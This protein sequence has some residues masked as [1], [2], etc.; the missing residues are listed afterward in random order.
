MDK[1]V[2]EGGVRLEGTV[3]VSGAKNSALPIM[4]ASMLADGTCEILGVPRVRDVDTLLKLL[5]ILGVAHE[6][7]GE[8]VRL[9]VVNDEPRTAPYELVSQMRASICVLGPLLA[10]RGV[11]RV[12]LPGGCAIGNRPIDL[13]RKGIEA[14]GA[15][16]RVDHGYVVA[17]AERL[18]GASV[19]LAGPFGST[20]LGTANTI[21]AASLA[22]GVT[23][24]ECAACEP[25][26]QD[27]ANF[28]NKMG[29]S[30]EGAGSPVV[31]I[32]GVRRLTSTRHRIIPDRVEAATFM[33]AA[34]M[35][36]GDV[37]LENVRPEHLGA[38]IHVL[39]QAGAEIMVRDNSCR[40]LGPETIRPVD[41]TTL[42]YPGVPTDVQAQLMA[43]LCLADGMSVVTEKVFP[44]RFMHAA[45]LQRMGARLR[46]ESNAVIVS[47][48]R[49]LSGAKV[50][51]SDLRASACLVLA[52]LVGK[53][54]T[55]VRRVYHIDRGYERIEE[56]LRALG[57][58]IWRCN[59]D[60]MPAE[61]TAGETVGAGTDV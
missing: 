33:I 48:V 10:R 53:G 39:R 7:E 38:V 32:K 9:T 31:T 27:L 2:V 60:E 52:G 14:L 45:E 59:E 55:E 41:V 20:V 13:H 49:Q 22:E 42:P 35:T 18:R 56:K 50:M 3:R 11:A 12:S 34:T 19:F 6:R 25:E 58:R 36:G 8:A 44:D 54:V 26:I 17:E 43:M 5:E 51:A 21:M 24:I 23:T 47:G 61:L 1:I 30:V 57:A 16:T 28:I 4:A 29:G 37:T 40:V 15:V 46:K